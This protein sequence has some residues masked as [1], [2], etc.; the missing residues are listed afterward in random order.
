MSEQE[1]FHAAM[2]ADPNDWQ[3]RAVYADW[4]RERDD[5]HLRAAGE[6]LHWWAHLIPHLDGTTTARVTGE[7][8]VHH[9]PPW[10]RALVAQRHWREMRTDRPLPDTHYHKPYERHAMNVLWPTNELQ[11]LGLHDGPAPPNPVYTNAHTFAGNPDEALTYHLRAEHRSDLTRAMIEHAKNP[12]VKLARVK[13]A[14]IEPSNRPQGTVLVKV[15]NPGPPTPPPAQSN[16][17]PATDKKSAPAS[18]PA[19]ILPQ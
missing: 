2:A 4:L 15:P 10:V 1:A 13:L 19:F 16:P 11:A 12:P 18:G 9:L 14:A 6:K 17:A 5:P 3:T 7:Q 8:A